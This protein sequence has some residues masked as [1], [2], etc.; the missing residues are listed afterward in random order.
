ME[1]HHTHGNSVPSLETRGLVLF[2]LWPLERDHRF[3]A[4]AAAA[5][6]NTIPS[7]SFKPET[8]PGEAEEKIQKESDQTQQEKDQ[9]RGGYKPEPGPASATNGAACASQSVTGTS[10]GA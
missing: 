1:K 2:Q 9:S 10:D 8:A 3:R 6:A 4:A 7:G 5:A